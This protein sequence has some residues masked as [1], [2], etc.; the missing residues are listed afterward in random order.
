P[1]YATLG[2]QVIEPLYGALMPGGYRD[3]HITHYTRESLTGILVGHGFVHEETAYVAR[4]ELIMRFRKP[5]VIDIHANGQAELSRND[6]KQPAAYED[7][8]RAG[9]QA[10]IV[11]RS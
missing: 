4:S 2:W 9:Q 7:E 11:A 8:R 5:G 6:N 1:D 10:G 3:E